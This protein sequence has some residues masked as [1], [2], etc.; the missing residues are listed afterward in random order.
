MDF[1]PTLPGGPLGTVTGLLLIIIGII[2]LLFPGL[3][4]VLIV[5]FLAIFAVIISIELIRSGISRPD[6]T[7]VYRS[8]QIVGGIAGV[9]LGFFVMVL[10]Y[11][12]PVAARDLFGIWAILTGA[13]NILSISGGNSGRERGLNAISGLVL[14][15]VGL[16]I[17]LAPAIVTDYILVVVLSFLAIIIGI[18]SIWFARANTPAENTVDHSMYK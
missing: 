4:F 11:F 1:P 13:A 6:E 7:N 5:V 16:L 17:L 12:F 8:L 10:P 9:I 3:A 2:A 14:A 18:F 15:I